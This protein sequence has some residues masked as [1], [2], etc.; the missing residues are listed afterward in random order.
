MS[1]FVAVATQERHWRCVSDS[2]TR[3]SLKSGAL[4]LTPNTPYWTDTAKIVQ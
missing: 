4:R 1:Y 3:Q 2:V